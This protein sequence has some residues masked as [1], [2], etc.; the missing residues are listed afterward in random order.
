MFVVRAESS[1]SSD[2]PDL[3][4]MLAVSRSIGPSEERSRAPDDPLGATLHATRTA[5]GH[6]STSFLVKFVQ[7]S[8][9]IRG[10]S[11]SNSQPSE[12]KA[13]TGKLDKLASTV[14][15]L[16]A[17][18]SS[19]GKCLDISHCPKKSKNKFL[20]AIV[21]KEKQEVVVR[22]APPLSRFEDL[23]K[24]HRDKFVLKRAGQEV[25][26]KFQDGNCSDQGCV[27]A[28]VCAACGRNASWKQCRCLKFD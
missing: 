28:H 6:F 8:E 5:K 19:G 3:N 10:S 22:K 11:F 1:G 21:G 2:G 17:N 16:A 24:E 4:E 23:L 9:A 26:Y 14:K 13:F 27:R 7:L 20:E 18:S 12:V 15:L 25:C